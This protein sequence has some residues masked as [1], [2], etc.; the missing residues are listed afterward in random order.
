MKVKANGHVIKI[1]IVLR[2]KVSKVS[3]VSKVFMVT[4][5]GSSGQTYPITAIAMVWTIAIV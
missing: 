1:T 2:G 3:K 4:S 5:L